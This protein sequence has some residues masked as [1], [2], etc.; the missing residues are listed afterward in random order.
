MLTKHEKRNG[1]VFFFWTFLKCPFFKKPDINFLKKRFY[2]VM[3]RIG[4][5]LRKIGCIT[6]CQFLRGMR[7]RHD[8]VAI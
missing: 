5:F 4:V 7:T 8:F 6:F 2:S 1:C 3:Q